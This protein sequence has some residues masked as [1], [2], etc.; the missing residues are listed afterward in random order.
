M[1]N[2]DL[3]KVLTTFKPKTIKKQKC[4]LFELPLTF[5]SETSWNHDE[6]N[7]MGWIYSWA[8]C[9]D[10][11]NNIYYFGRNVNEFIA[12]LKTINE[13]LE[14]YSSKY[15]ACY[16]VVI[17][18]H[19]LPYDYNYIYRPLINAFTIKHEFFIDRRH[20]ISVDV[21][22]H[23]ILKDSLIY[24]NSSL[25]K[26]TEKYNVPHKKLIG[27]VDYNSIHYSDEPL[28]QNDVDY[29]INDVFGLQ[30]CLLSDFN[31]CGYDITNAPLTSTGKIRLESRVNAWLTDNYR[32][33]FLYTMPTPR[34]FRY[35]RKT[36]SGGYCHGNRFKRG[37]TVFDYIKHRDFRS[38][39]PSV[40]RKYTFPSGRIIEI[41]HPKLNDF[42][43]DGFNVWGVVAFDSIE[44][45]DKKCVAPYLSRSKCE[46]ES[47]TKF[48]CDNGRV[49]ESSG[50]FITY[51]TEYDLQ[52]ILEQYSYKE[53]KVLIAFK[54]ISKPLPKWFINEIDNYYK[55]KSDL[56]AKVN[57]LKSI[58]APRDE[59]FDAEIELQ[60]VKAFLN[61][62]YGLTAMD[63]CKSDFIRNDDGEIVQ[64]N[65]NYRKKIDDYYGIYRNKERPEKYYTANTSTGFL[66]YYWSLYVTSTARFELFKY[67]KICGQNFL[68]ADTD[69]IYYIYDEKIE[70]EIE[71]LNAEKLEN[72]IKN[73]TYITTDK[74]EIITYDSFDLEDTGTQFRFLHSKCYAY[75]TKNELKT[76]ISGVANRRLI[77]VE[78]GKPQYLYNSDELGTIKNLRDNFVFEKCGSTKAKYVSGDSGYIDVGGGHYELVY[79]A[80]IITENEK[81]LSIGND[82]FIKN[83]HYES[84][85]KGLYHS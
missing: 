61:G 12:V 17:Y 71:K 65:I 14:S 85:V 40:M 50:K 25:E 11:K 66:P 81:T 1:K 63:F 18:C 4:E 20:I 47:G 59:I 26:I 29:Q 10:A 53:I 49:L 67:I 74:G 52:I 8:L 35:M 69:S 13:L 30:E 2:M 77:N 78:N 34:Q 57:R 62:L 7:P 39:Y 64:T 38:H 73:N 37:I 83:Y 45:K 3:T 51:V 68:Y 55:L 80:V 75:V 41:K 76:V 9:I 5:D 27:L 23:I 84:V 44:L 42:F 28:T 54:A 72:A 79:D 60:R 24:F 33:D 43:L 36:F 46:S 19:N 32:K 6:V 15:H 22:K 48:Y 21:G 70:N 58:N 31:L 56:K 82:D 16:K